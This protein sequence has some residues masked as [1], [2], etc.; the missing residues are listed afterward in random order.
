MTK[1]LPFILLMFIFLS[2]KGIAQNNSTIEHTAPTLQVGLDA[3]NFSR[4]TLDAEL[5]MQIVAEKQQEVALKVVQNM[6]LKRM[7]DSGGA[8]YS[9]TDNIVRS[10]VTERDVNLIT[11][12]LLENTVN[13][14]F[15]YAFADF[16][17]KNLTGNHLT[18]FNSLAK[19][20]TI[21]LKTDFTQAQVELGLKGLYKNNTT[22]EEEPY[23]DENTTSLIA[24]ISDIS[25]EV[26]RHNSSL[27]QLGV[28][29]VSY[30]QSYEFMNT[31]LRL[32]TKDPTDYS[33]ARV[34][35]DDME[36]TLSSYTNMIGILNYHIQAGSYRP[37]GANAIR[38][39]APSHVGSY[40]GPQIIADL[41]TVSDELSKSIILMQNKMIAIQDTFIIKKI[42][43]DLQ[44]LGQIHS[45]IS[46]ANLYYQKHSTLNSTQGSND[47]ETKKY[48]QELVANSDIVYTLYTD[49]I[50]KLNSMV[51]WDIKLIQNQEKLNNICRGIENHY[52]KDINNPLNTISVNRL[53]SFLTSI[54]KMYQ[55]DRANTFSTSVHLL[56]ELDGIFPNERINDALAFIS[57][58]IRDFVTISTDKGNHEYITIN[59]ESLLSNLNTVKPDRLRRGSVLF[60]VGVNT[61]YFIK[62]LSL[63]NQETIQ[64]FSYISEKIGI[65]YKIKDYNFWMTRNPGETYTI[66][67]TQYKKIKPPTEPAVSDIH[68]LLYGSGILYNI[69]NS[70][71]SKSFNHPMVGAG[72]GLTFYNSLDLNITAGIPIIKSNSIENSFQSW[73]IGLGFDFPFSEY[74]KRLSDKRENNKNKKLI[75]D[76]IR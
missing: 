32:Y 74:I 14:T 4:G 6:F 5:I 56:A 47:D 9:F 65:K 73:F 69:I 3:L 42:H 43:T 44:T 59:L 19:S 28:M 35:Y 50:P 29:Q 18:H 27:K 8:F 63:S 1:H 49:I 53:A 16:Y 61:S 36:K 64:N 17:I 7:E 30:A 60:T 40:D 34:I 72:F 24:L 58:Y 55:F 23:I 10:I 45:Y 54:S 52:K 57:T 48:T 68:L 15:T 33:K 70:G 26:I 76:V 39:F 25:S 22:T 71:T 62:P 11:R 37:N 20:T 75:A 41:N 46:K 2:I 51:V 66:D 31:F 38:D 21:G 12:K 67:G 13:I